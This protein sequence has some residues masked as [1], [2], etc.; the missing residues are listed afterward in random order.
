MFT[1]IIKESMQ[2]LSLF[3]G[4]GGFEVAIHQVFPQAHCLGFSEVNRNCIKLYSA[5]FP[6]HK[7][8]GDIK[9]IDFRPFIGHVD[10]VVA[11]FPCQDLSRANA[12]RKRLEGTKSSLVREV[13]R[14]LKECKPRFFL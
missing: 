4:I 13:L 14:C 8:L 11:G 2:Y 9:E 10:L 7:N 3:S 6:D 5:H 12:K 1:A